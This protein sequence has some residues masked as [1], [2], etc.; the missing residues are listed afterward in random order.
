LNRPAV[1]CGNR[2]ALSSR[3]VRA[4]EMEIGEDWIA[5]KRYVTMDT[6]EEN[7]NEKRI[8]RKNVM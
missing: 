4:V 8:Y 2:P 6:E 1:W 7:E 5:G 3:L